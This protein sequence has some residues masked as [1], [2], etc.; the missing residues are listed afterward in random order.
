MVELPA[1]AWLGIG[2]ISLI[3]LLGVLHVLAT[4][5]RNEAFLHDLRREVV[6]KR[7]SI[8][9]DLSRHEGADEKIE[10]AREHAAK[11]EQA[12]VELAEAA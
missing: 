6:A 3:T 9:S 8:L 7:I 5:I 1:A 12:I 10:L 4:V 2:A 11:A